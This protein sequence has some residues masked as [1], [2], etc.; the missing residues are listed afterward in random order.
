MS[1]VIQRSYV[2]VGSVN[3][4]KSPMGQLISR[5]SQTER[6]KIAA[7]IRG[8]K[9]QNL[10]LELESVP[11]NKKGV[12]WARITQDIYKAMSKFAESELSTSEW[13]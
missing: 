1:N 2:K 9:P 10:W 13:G 7:K 12:W 11:N 5:M 3:Y 4:R 8:E 6:I